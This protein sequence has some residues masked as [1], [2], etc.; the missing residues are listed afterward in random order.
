MFKGGRNIESGPR[1][2]F[3]MTSTDMTHNTYLPSTT[4]SSGNGVVKWR[5]TSLGEGAGEGAG[6][7]GEGAGEWN[8]HITLMKG[9]RVALE[10]GGV[11]LAVIAL[12]A[13]ASDL[14]AV[15]WEKQK[16]SIESSAI[17]QDL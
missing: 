13:G 5:S 11:A 12:G 1:L 16:N 10:V 14:G 15:G 8:K 6:S 9:A 17:G 7:L 2:T 3:V 4:R